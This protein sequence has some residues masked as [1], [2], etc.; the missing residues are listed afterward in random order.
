MIFSSNA[1]TQNGETVHFTA[2]R[3]VRLIYTLEGEQFR[4]HLKNSQFWQSDR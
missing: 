1:G 4:R 3:G 2:Q